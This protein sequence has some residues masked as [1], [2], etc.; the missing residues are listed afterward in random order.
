MLTAQYHYSYLCNNRYVIDIFLFSM[1]EGTVDC[2]SQ[3]HS[4]KLYEWIFQKGGVDMTWSSLPGVFRLRYK[5][6][7]Y[8][9]S[10]AEFQTGI[11]VV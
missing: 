6:V 2:Q 3:N 5:N 8:S 7:S 1:S 4:V 11:S 9:V 10:H